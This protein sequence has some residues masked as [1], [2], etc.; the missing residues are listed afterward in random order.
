MSSVELAE[1]ES[2]RESGGS[3]RASKFELTA[4]E[5]SAEDRGE[6]RINVALTEVISQ[7]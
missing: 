1:L 3:P 7:T 6:K 2:E 5:S 4:S